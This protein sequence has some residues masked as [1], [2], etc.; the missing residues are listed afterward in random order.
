MNNNNVLLRGDTVMEEVMKNEMSMKN[1][2]D[3]T[4]TVGYNHQPFSA[5]KKSYES[6]ILQIIVWGLN[7]CFPWT[8]LTQLK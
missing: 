3:E 6:H 5:H 7:H 1:I 8:Q 2:H 4:K